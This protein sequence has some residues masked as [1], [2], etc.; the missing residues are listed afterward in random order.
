MVS[1]ASRN[2]SSLGARYAF[3]QISTT[4]IFTSFNC[5]RLHS[6]SRGPASPVLPCGKPADR[7][8]KCLCSLLQIRSVRKCLHFQ[9]QL[10]Q[11]RFL[12][13]NPFI[14]LFLLRCQDRARLLQRLNTLL[15][16]TLPGPGSNIACLLLPGNRAFQY[17]NPVMTICP[18]P[19]IGTAYLKANLLQHRRDLLV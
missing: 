1:P 15:P 5:F 7:L 4:W 13:S 19:G 11:S 10:F 3:S 14:C 12:A 16:V 6:D 8:S 18:D 9:L 17:A 2:R